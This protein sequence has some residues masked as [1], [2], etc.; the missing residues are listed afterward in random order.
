M[1]EH[2]SHL[3]QQAPRSESGPPPVPT[4]AKE[5]PAGGSPG[6]VNAI[7]LGLWLA[8]AAT[9]LFDSGSIADLWQ[10]FR[11]WPLLAQIVVGVL[12]LPWTVA[13]WVWQSG[14]ADWLRV[15]IVVLLALATIATCSPRGRL[16]NRNKRR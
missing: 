10:R 11:D 9:I 14:W 6:G 16:A 13:S 5:R 4:K 8:F 7:V 15:M 2:A 3:S 1:V 12:L